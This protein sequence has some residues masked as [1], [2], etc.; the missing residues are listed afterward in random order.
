MDSVKVVICTGTTCYVMGSSE[1]HALAE[2]LTPEDAARVE[3][4]GAR[5]LGCC[6]NGQYGKAPYVLI[7]GQVV[8]EANIPTVLTEL[9]AILHPQDS[10]EEQGVPR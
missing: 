4:T 9:R 8:G 5:C 6:T 10:G 1:L 2:Y 7:N 3:I